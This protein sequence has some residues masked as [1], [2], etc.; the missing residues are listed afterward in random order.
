MQTFVVC[1][2]IYWRV[3]GSF[4]SQCRFSIVQRITG[5]CE[6]IVECGGHSLLLQQCELC[7]Y[8]WVFCSTMLFCCLFVRYIVVQQF[9][10]SRDSIYHIHKT[11][12][13]TRAI[14]CVYECFCI[15]YDFIIWFC[16]TL[17][18]SYRMISSSDVSFSD[19]FCKQMIDVDRCVRVTVYIN[20]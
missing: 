15:V 1:T 10:C 13:H 3:V 16:S 5:M 20:E 14:R 17:L 12:T 11:Y 7:S 4:S 8:V 19:F 2:S 9:I 18:C 6:W